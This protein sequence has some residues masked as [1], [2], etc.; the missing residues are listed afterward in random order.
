[1]NICGWNVMR[2]K[3]FRVVKIAL[4]YHGLTLF[5]LSQPSFVCLIPLKKINFLFHPIVD[6]GTL[7]GKTY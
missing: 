6:D 1:M 7:K 3:I 4:N 5:P 2:V